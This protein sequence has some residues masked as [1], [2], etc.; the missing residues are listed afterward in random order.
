MPHVY[1]K[2]NAGLRSG[3]F[4]F[5]PRADGRCALFVYLYPR[6]KSRSYFFGALAKKVIASSSLELIPAQIAL[7]EQ[8]LLHI[9]CFKENDTPIAGNIFDRIDT[10]LFNALR[11]EA[12]SH[13]VGSITRVWGYRTIVKHANALAA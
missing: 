1:P 13:G 10:A 3:D 11:S 12:H 2:S 8:A 4:C 7:D 6:A 9:K 5:V